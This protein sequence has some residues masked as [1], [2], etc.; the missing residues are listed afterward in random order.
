MPDLYPTPSLLAL[1][2]EV[3][4]LAVF[5]DEIGD[6]YIAAD[7]KVT[8]RMAELKAADWVKLVPGGQPG[9]FQ[10]PVWHLTETG[11]A[12]LVTHSP[13]DIKEQ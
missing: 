8:A 4:A 13:N 2:R 6:S 3:A 11:E 9:S 1:L 5:Q 7:R 10:L 12:V